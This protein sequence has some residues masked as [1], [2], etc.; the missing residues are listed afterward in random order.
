MRD[1]KPDTKFNLTPLHVLLL[2]GGILGSGNPSSAGY[3]CWMA[4]SLADDPGW[5]LC[6]AGVLLT[7]SVSY[8][9]AGKQ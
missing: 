2:G 5:S 4:R 8:R 1:E 3:C 6:G 7:A 9:Q